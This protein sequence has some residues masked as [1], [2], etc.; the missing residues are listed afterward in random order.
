MRVLVEEVMLDGPRVL[1]AKRVGQHDL[2]DRLVDET[3]FVALAPRLWQLQLVENTK[4][5]VRSPL[6]DR[7]KS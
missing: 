2:L 6:F 7:T 5:H 4:S 1:D 3:L